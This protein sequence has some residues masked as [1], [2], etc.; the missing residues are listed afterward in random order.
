MV[1]LCTK[2]NVK[3]KIRRHILLKLRVIIGC[4]KKCEETTNVAYNVTIKIAVAKKTSGKNILKW[5]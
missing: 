4:P 3:K 5:F 1:L 2:I